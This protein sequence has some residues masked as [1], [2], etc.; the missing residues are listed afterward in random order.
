MADDDKAAGNGA[1]DR[2]T[3]DNTSVGGETATEQL[4]ARFGGLRPLA[5]KLGIAVST[6]QGWKTRGHIPPTRTDEIR[7]AAAE[8]G[9]TLDEAELAAAT[10]EQPQA[11]EP[12]DT[13][14]SE[15]SL[16]HI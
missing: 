11:T 1:D 8:H 15:L 16:I 12:V 3:A 7:K 10:A 4:I 2:A 6:V 13:A 5:G 14:A 9:I